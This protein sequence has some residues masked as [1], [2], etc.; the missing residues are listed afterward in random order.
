MRNIIRL[1]Q[2]YINFILFLILQVISFIFIFN[3]RNNYHH[4][5]Y[6]SSSNYIIG[7][8]YDF[9]SAVTDYFLLEDINDQLKKENEGLKEDI[10]NQEIILGE[11][12]NIADY[13]H[14]YDFLSSKV[15]NSKFKSRLNYMT[16]NIGEESGVKPNMGV[17]GTKGILGYTISCSPYYSIVLPIIN[18]LFELNVIIF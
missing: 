7:S 8:V 4:S 1:I 5:S 16:I 18:P 10:F 6:L 9:K 15:I 17:I 3:W 14:Q 11:I 12:F 2:K 13:E